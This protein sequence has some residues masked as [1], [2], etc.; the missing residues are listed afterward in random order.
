[1]KMKKS[2]SWYSVFDGTG[3]TFAITWSPATRKNRKTLEKICQRPPTDLGLKRIDGFLFLRKT[4]DGF[5]WK[6]YN[7][8]GSVA[9]MCGNAA[10]CA[11]EF[12][13]MQH[14][15]KKF[16]LQAGQ[17]EVFCQRIKKQQ[18]TCKWKIFYQPAEI[19][20]HF[21]VNTGVPHL[22]L[23][24][25]PS[26]AKAKRLRKLKYPGPT[27]SN[28][29]FVQGLK[30]RTFE[31]GVEDFTLSCGTGALAAALFNH[32]I[33]RQA[34]PMDILTPGGK[35]RVDFQFKKSLVVL[36][37]AVKKILDRRTR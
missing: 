24:E 3:N 14:H 20:G 30:T 29:T 35:L 19:K 13:F 8:D 31:R 7:Q 16:I 12:I 22:V 25:P 4:K 32:Q 6:F 1:M 18:W 11:S 34:F 9:E 36:R 10:R 28:V 23:N 5:A 15:L 21:F 17:I 2:K 37:G 26:E 33:K 27:G